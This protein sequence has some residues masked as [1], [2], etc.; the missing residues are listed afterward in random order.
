MSDSIR[1]SGRYYRQYPPDAHKGYASEE[2]EFKLEETAFLMVDVYGKGYDDDCDLGDAP[3]LYRAAVQR[4]KDIVV[5]HIRPAKDAAR[6][7]GLPVIYLNNYLAPSTNEHT[8]WRNMSIRTC[9][10]DVLEAWQ[11]PNDVLSF[12]KVIAPEEGDHFIQKQMYSGFFETHLDS[13]LRSLSVRNLVVVGFDLRICLGTTVTDA[14]YRNYR[15][16]VLRD[17][18]STTE[19]P[20]TEAEQ[21]ATWLGVRFVEANV[22]YTSTSEAFVL[23]CKEVTP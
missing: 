20:E 4:N 18:C 1:F 15:V 10:I 6:A 19:Y 8:E 23:A 13:L 22:G 12:S 9:G 3:E 11:E 17:C 7:V 2:L 16:A 14:M 5:D 21:W